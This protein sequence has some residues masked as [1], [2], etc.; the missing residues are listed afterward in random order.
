MWDCC[1][2]WWESVKDLVGYCCEVKFCVDSCPSGV[3]FWAQSVVRVGSC[4]SWLR[5]YDFFME[6]LGCCCSANLVDE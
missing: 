2:D 4:F 3:G 5:C 1:E 6:I